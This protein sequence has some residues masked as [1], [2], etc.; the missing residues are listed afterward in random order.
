MIRAGRGLDRGV[1]EVDRLVDL[2]P[3]ELDTD[4]MKPVDFTKLGHGIIRS[5][6]ALQA[7]L[8][9]LASFASRQVIHLTREITLNRRRAQQG[10]PPSKAISAA[11]F[12][13]RI[14]PA[15]AQVL[16]YFSMVLDIEGVEELDDLVAMDGD[17]LL[18]FA[19]S[20]NLLQMGPS[21]MEERMDALSDVVQFL[22]VR[23]GSLNERLFLF[24]VTLKDLGRRLSD[25]RPRAPRFA[26]Q[27]ILENSERYLGGFYDLLHHFQLRLRHMTDAAIARQQNLCYCIRA[28]VMIAFMTPFLGGHRAQTVA[29]LQVS[30]GPCITCGEGQCRGN[31][32][33]LSEGNTVRVIISHHKNQLA[34]RTRAIID[35]AVED[36][37]VADLLRVYL[38]VARPR[39]HGHVDNPNPAGGGGGAAGAARAEGVS[40]HDRVHTTNDHVLLTSRA[41]ELT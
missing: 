24:A 15:V 10:W 1:I 20:I 9:S 19:A 33:V 25:L 31:R 5:S 40:D 29:R 12:V 23:R 41:R 36:S 22:S 39:L 6:P 21:V 14:V 27:S 2:V 3:D 8:R 16:G 17:Y 4:T 35:Y 13:K 28:L 30:D 26:D 7:E 18:S 38:R 32:V 11:K 34:G 37:R